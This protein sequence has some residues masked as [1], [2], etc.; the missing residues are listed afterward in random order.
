MV[1]VL[2]YGGACCNGLKERVYARG[3]GR[4]LGAT[5]GTYVGVPWSGCL[6]LAKLLESKWLVSQSYGL[7]H[8]SSPFPIQ[9]HE[10]ENPAISAVAP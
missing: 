8:P 10:G 6:Y 9:S 1:A 2:E 4:H 7:G 5:R 3:G